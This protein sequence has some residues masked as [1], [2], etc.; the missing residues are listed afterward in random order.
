MSAKGPGQ[1]VLKQLNEAGYEAYFVG[2]MVRDT[3]LGHNVCDADVTTDAMPEVVLDLFNKAFATGLQHGTVTVVMDGENVEVT[4]FRLDGD[5]LDNR[6][7]EGVIF[8]RSLSEDLAR[9]DFTINAMA[10]ELDGTVI[11]PFNGQDDLEAEMIRAVGDP[12]KRFEEDALRILR[13]VRFV[14]KLGFD[15]EAETLRAMKDCRH[16]LANLS[17]ER[18]RKEFEGIIEGEYRAKALRIMLDHELFNDIPF[19]SV[20]CRYNHERLAKMDEF[21]VVLLILEMS[22]QSSNFLKCFPL[23]KGEKKLIQDVDHALLRFRSVECDILV[24]YYFGVDTLR[25]MAKFKCIYDGTMYIE[26]TPYRLPIKN[27]A[28][29]AIGPEEVIKLSKKDPGS[30]VG[31]LFTEIEEAVILEEIKNTRE[32]IL[33]LIEKRGIFNVEEN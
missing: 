2:G 27:R 11:D 3:M 18:I 17:L 28:D 29:L 4:T 8:T 25:I 13:G 23:T 9:R 24:Q 33:K 6:R 30:W 31:K 19:F 5:Y 26:H 1:K 14:A 22:D 16:L 15:I 32:S 21:N 20:L 10:Q 12:K 7:P